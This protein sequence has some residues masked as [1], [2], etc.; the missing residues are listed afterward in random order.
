MHQNVLV[1]IG[2]WKCACLRRTKKKKDTI[3]EEG[4]QWAMQKYAPQGHNEKLL[5]RNSSGSIFTAFSGIIFRQ[6]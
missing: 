3:I 6:G 5:M 4:L 1:A 2:A